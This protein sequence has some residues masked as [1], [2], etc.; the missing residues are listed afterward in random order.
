MWGEKRL[1]LS[2]TELEPL[3]FIYWSS[4]FIV[5]VLGDRDLGEVIKVEW[6]HKDEVLIQ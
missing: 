6:D 4:N 3:K 2:V 5:T 1:G